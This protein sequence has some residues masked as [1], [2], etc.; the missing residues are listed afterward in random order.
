MLVDGHAIEVVE[1]LFELARLT[2]NI[3]GPVEVDQLLDGFGL[4]IHL[5]FW[6]RIE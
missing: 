3:E 2:L 4:W 1:D 5:F 6:K